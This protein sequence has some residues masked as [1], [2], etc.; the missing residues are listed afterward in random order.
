MTTPGMMPGVAPVFEWEA[1]LIVEFSIGLAI[2][3]LANW[4]PEFGFSA[5]ARTITA[6]ESAISPISSAKGAANA[7][8]RSQLAN[9]PCT[10]RN[11]RPNRIRPPVAANA[12]H[13][14]ASSAPASMAA[15]SAAGE[16]T[17]TTNKRAIET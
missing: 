9:T 13:T 1:G 14:K 11:D 4:V 7:N 12:D 5:L 6:A 15:T 10:N 3:P 8:C 2:G 17:N 16:S